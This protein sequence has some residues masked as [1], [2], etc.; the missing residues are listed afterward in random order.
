MIYVVYLI[1]KFLKLESNKEKITTD[2]LEITI[3]LTTGKKE[4][5]E[6]REKGKE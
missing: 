1:K 6:G 5:K 2:F 4:L 3:F